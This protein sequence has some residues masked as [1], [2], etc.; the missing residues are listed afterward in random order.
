MTVLLKF[1]KCFNS[2]KD[3]TIIWSLNTDI[4]TK[5]MNCQDLVQCMKKKS[6][7]NSDQ[8]NQNIFIL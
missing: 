8:M 1:E 5:N 7:D 6:S 2:R 4:Q 3:Y